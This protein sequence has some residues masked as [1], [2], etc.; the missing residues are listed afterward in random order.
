MTALSP[1]TSSS[2]TRPTF[3]NLLIESEIVAHGIW[4]VHPFVVDVVIFRPEVEA[5]ER[6]KTSVISRGQDVRCPPLKIT[7][8]LY[9]GV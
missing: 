1:N 6:I 9:V 3:Q 4:L 8:Y 2:V 7:L 5:V